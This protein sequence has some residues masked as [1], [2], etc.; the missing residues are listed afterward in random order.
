MSDTVNQAEP[1][2]QTWPSPPKMRQTWSGSVGSAASNAVDPSRFPS[3]LYFDVSSVTS[4]PAW[5]ERPAWGHR[6][7]RGWAGLWHK[8]SACNHGDMPTV[9]GVDGVAVGWYDLDGWMVRWL[10]D[11]WLYC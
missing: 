7:K 11:G 6:V 3:P 1:N 8:A 2:L 4:T 10:V 9:A 5:S